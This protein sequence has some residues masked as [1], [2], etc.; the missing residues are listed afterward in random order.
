MS[1]AHQ[2]VVCAGVVPEPLRALEPI[3]SSPGPALK[4][5]LMLPAVLDPW[6]SHAL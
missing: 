5:D 4:N 1:T 6:A 2:I 3:A